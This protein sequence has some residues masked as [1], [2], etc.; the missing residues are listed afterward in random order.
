MRL[1]CCLTLLLALIA[2]CYSDDDMVCSG[3]LSVRLTAY[4]LVRVSGSSSKEISVP[5]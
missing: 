2:L 4:S 5:V 3:S 1:Y